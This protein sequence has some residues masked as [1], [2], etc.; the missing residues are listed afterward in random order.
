MFLDIEKKKS[1]QPAAL[2]AD[3]TAVTY[4]ALCAFCREAAAVIPRRSLI[5]AF[6]KNTIGS[7]AGYVAFL[8][9]QSVPL[10]LSADLDAALLTY[11]LD[12][13]HPNYLWVPEEKQ[14]E[15]NGT[16]I[17]SGFGYGLLTYDE[18]RVTMDPSLAL[19]LT[20]SG[21]T[22]SPKLVRQSYRNIT[23]NAQSIVEYLELDETERPIT[24]LPMQ[25]TYGLS[26]INSHLLAGATILMT[27]NSYM[28]KQ[29]WDFFAQERATSLVGVPY[30]YEILKKLRL[31]RMELPSLRYMTQAGGKL[32]PALHKEFAT[33]AQQQGKRFYVM[34]GQTEAT[35]RMSYLPYE[36]ALD[37]CGS[38]GIAIPGG[39]F[40]LMD[41]NGAEIHDPDIVGELVYYGANVTL[42]YAECMA[43]LAK[44]DERKGILHTGDMA[45]MDADGYFYI[46]GRKKRFLKLFG[47]RVNMDEVERMVSTAYP[48]IRCAC[49]GKDDALRL[50]IEQEGLADTEKQ[51]LEKELIHFLA[52][53]THLHPSAFGITWIARIPM[54]DA[55]KIQYSEL[56]RMYESI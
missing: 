26:V 21:S 44:G 25:Y 29:F 34:Y 38:M 11:L 7:L 14:A 50:Y 54:N 12:T 53:K 17:F 37:K 8:S 28:Q 20:T 13:Y 48:D 46:V 2:Q 15:F 39:R 41:G 47:N 43:D 45:R 56:E 52:E 36:K 31:F 49:A 6:C 3:G 5:F 27:E 22:G 35:A 30:T 23:A 10:L 19:L 1:E 51:R 18:R 32:S 55:G 42:G 40:V 33:Y 9:G 4:G 24:M 16:C